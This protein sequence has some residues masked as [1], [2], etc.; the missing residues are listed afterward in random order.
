MGQSKRRLV[1]EVLSH[2]GLDIV[3]LME[4]KKSPFC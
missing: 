3:L 2:E 4:T 1:K